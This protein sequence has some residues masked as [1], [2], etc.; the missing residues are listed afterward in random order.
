M[1]IGTYYYPEQWPA[2]QWERDFDNI[3]KMGMQIV[4][5][6][7][8]AWFTMEPE[9]GRFQFEWLH[10]CVDMAAKRKMDVILCTPTA[11]PPIWLTQQHPDVLP[12]DRNGARARHG[13]R[14]HY[15]PTS[16]RLREAAA[17]IVSKLATEFS[18]HPS[19]IGW[20]IDNE[21]SSN[22]F[23]QNP[24][25]HE[26]FRGWL[27]RKYG[28]ID[29]L[30]DAWGNQ[31]WNQFYTSFN[32]I[33][34]PASRDPEY[35][36]PHHVLDASRFWSWAMADFNRLQAN[37]LKETGRGA[38]DAGRTPFI[39]TNFVP[40]SPDANP[41]DMADDL[42]LYTWDAYPVNGAGRDHKN[43][44]FRI[45]DPSAMGIHHDLMRSFHDRWA[46]MELQPGQVNWSGI[47]V[48]LYPGA[49][50]LWLWTAY[51]HGAEFVTTYRFRQPRFGIELFHHGLVGTDGVT[52]SP[53][54]RQ[55]QQTIEEMRRL[56]HL[57]PSD[58]PQPQSE[59][60]PVA[61]KS[62]R[63]RGSDVET[64]QMPSIPDRPHVAASAGLMIDFDQLW[65]FRTLPQSRRWDYPRLL[66]MWYTAMTRLGLQVKIIHP[67]RPWPGDLKMLV[68]PAMQMVDDKLVKR[69]DEYA[70]AGGH[71][72]LTCRTG[73]MDRNGQIWEGP[74]AKPILTLIG[75]SIE[76]YDGLPDDTFGNIEMDSLL[77]K[78]GVWG[79]LLFAEDQTRPLAKY[80]DQFY[81]GAI[82]VS[83][84]RHGSG[85]VTYCG[86]FAEEEF[87]KALAEK[88]ARQWGLPVLILPDRTQLLQR[89]GFHVF[90]NYNETAINAPAHRTAR[91]IFGSRTVEPA[92]VAIWE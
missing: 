26:S 22:F 14:R 4:H 33:L 6:S 19:L 58:S 7:E 92:G 70:H 48:L 39:T 55:F 47:P 87:T 80:A 34:L 15:S 77:Y 67:D 16:P 44:A 13:G 21:Y 82:A 62:R 20:Q 38:G 51:A 12:L 17:R 27:M 37:I 64:V 84:K 36:N 76:A 78:W 56:K 69:F 3:A 18:G 72:V 53:G 57:P 41:A 23:D 74:T 73:L 24:H 54:G 83:Q 9:P 35:G 85:D 52:P 71:L 79:D 46:I 29:A 10:K 45:A 61:K 11:A 5:M 65:Y 91:F 75:A 86:V 40:F 8:F 30:N 42:T 59:P 25:A 81:A 89:D 90:L 68:A 66:Q 28:A 60:E 50:R 88:L 1:K 2:E 43:E 49:V 63:R 32:Q 31:F